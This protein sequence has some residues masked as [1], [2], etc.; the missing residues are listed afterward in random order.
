MNTRAITQN[1]KVVTFGEVMLRLTAPI[2]SAFPKQTSLLLLME[3]V[4]E[5]S[6]I[7]GQLRHPTEFVTR[8]PENAMAQACVNSPKL[9]D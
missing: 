4:K 1:K 6:H 5:C 8:L 3:E 7:T 9:T 2:S